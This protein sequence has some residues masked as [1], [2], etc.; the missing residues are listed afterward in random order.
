MALAKVKEMVKENE[1]ENE[2]KKATGRELVIDVLISLSAL[3]G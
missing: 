1:N 2:R 3:G